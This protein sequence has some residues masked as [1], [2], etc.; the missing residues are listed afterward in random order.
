MKYQA[1]ILLMAAG[2][3]ALSVAKTHK[4]HPEYEDE[5]VEK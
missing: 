4:H 5:E 1:K 3:V 2:C